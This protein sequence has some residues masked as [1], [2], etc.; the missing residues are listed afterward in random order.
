MAGLLE[1][2]VTCPGRGWKGW[3]WKLLMLCSPRSSRTGTPSSQTSNLRESESYSVEPFLIFWKFEHWNSKYI[4][5]GTIH[6]DRTSKSKQKVDGSEYW[7]VFMVMWGKLSQ[8]WKKSTEKVWQTV[9]KNPNQVKVKMTLTAVCNE[10]YCPD[11]HDNEADLRSVH[12]CGW[13]SH[14]KIC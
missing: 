13:Y 11:R 3:R 4:D 5:L 14:L 7:M 10:V 8:S 6:P 9:L 12:H 1:K 2:I